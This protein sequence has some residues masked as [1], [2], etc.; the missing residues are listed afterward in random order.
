[1]KVIG[2]TGSLASGKSTVAGLLR[3][4]GAVVIDADKIAHELIAPR[5][6]CE[7]GVV[8]AFGRKILTGKRIDRKKLAAVVFA[9]PARL[10][11]LEAIVHPAV[12]RNLKEA[13]KKYRETDKRVVLEVPL[14]FES[15]L[16]RL[17]DVTVTVTA[18]RPQQLV[19]AMKHYGMSRAQASARIRAQMP[20]GRK[21]RL[22]DF[23]IDNKG[24]KKQTEKQVKSLWQRL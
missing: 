8:K 16:D 1:M 20:L 17:A 3:R 7:A 5:G 12:G 2:L 22:S 19:R 10:K 15:G 4:L 11:Q 6:A 24:T 18:R 14:L 23:T 13:L 9:H 21:V